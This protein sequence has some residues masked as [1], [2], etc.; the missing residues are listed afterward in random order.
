MMLTLILAATLMAA[1]PHSLPPPAT[2]HAAAKVA[3]AGKQPD[4]GGQAQAVP[5]PKVITRHTAVV[6]GK[7]LRYTVT[8]GFLPILND[9]G[10]AEAQI[11][12]VTYTAD[13]P[14]PGGRRPLLFIFN[15]GPG[16]ASVWLHLGAI[17]PKRVR[18]LDDGRM[19]APPFSPHPL[20]AHVSQSL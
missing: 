4:K 5:Q 16:A 14:S 15:G 7:E 10:E 11:F 8:A 12:S 17:G 2:D 9:A 1:T 20:H 18:M 3:D 19:P 6:G 13:V